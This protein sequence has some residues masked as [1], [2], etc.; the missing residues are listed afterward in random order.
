VAITAGICE[1]IVYRGYLQRQLSAFT[2]S[3][4]IAVCLQAAIFGAAHL[5][6]G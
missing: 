1:E 2:G 6:Q 3:L 4:P 5:Y